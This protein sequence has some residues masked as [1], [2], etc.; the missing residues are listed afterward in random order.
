MCKPRHGTFCVPRKFSHQ[1]VHN[2]DRETTRL[3]VGDHRRRVHVPVAAERR[4]ETADRVRHRQ[5]EMS[6]DRVSGIDTVQRAP[7]AHHVSHTGRDVGH[8]RRVAQRRGPGLLRVLVV[9]H[10]GHVKDGAVHG[11][12]SYAGDHMH[13]HSRYV[14]TGNPKTPSNRSVRNGV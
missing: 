10:R 12:R 1:P 7:D 8:R 11:W 13:G 5:V 9:H 2:D 14:Q 6:E 3:L 4:G